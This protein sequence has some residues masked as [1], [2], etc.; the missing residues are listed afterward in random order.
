MGTKRLILHRRLAATAVAAIVAVPPAGAL[1]TMPTA[2]GTAVAMPISGA[3]YSL[4]IPS[5]FVQRGTVTDINVFFHGDATTV[6]N[7]LAYSNLNTV[8][9]AVNLGALSSAYQ[10][11]YSNPAL[12][13]NV[14]TE[15]Q[16]ILRARPEFSDT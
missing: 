16:N 14:L 6:R 1:A 12:F 10:T 2:T 15:A 11:P 3:G 13:G 7:N 9:V 8:L 4:W 5:N